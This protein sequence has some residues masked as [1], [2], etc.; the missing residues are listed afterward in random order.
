M[1]RGITALENGAAGSTP[2]HEE[3]R[4]ARALPLPLTLSDA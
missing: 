1:D 3:A 2:A 4:I